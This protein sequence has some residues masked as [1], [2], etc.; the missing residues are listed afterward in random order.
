[1][2]EPNLEPSSHPRS[3]DFFRSTLYC[4]PEAHLLF[5]TIVLMQACEHSG[6]A[7]LIQAL[8]DLEPQALKIRDNSGFLCIHRAVL[9]NSLEAMATLLENGSADAI[10]IPTTE[11]NLLL[12]VACSRTP[13][14]D[15]V[16]RLLEIYPEAATH[17]RS[18]TRNV[19]SGCSPPS[20]CKPLPLHLLASRPRYLSRT[21]CS[22][23]I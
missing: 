21:R 12:H 6:S 9:N 13:A 14:V 4:E 11:G 15:V 2:R 7:E 23:S 22:P 19:S 8:I 18:L 5:F 3:K 17:P 10:R 20:A 1:M 16:E